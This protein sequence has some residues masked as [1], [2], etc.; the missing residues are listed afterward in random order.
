MSPPPG[1]NDTGSHGSGTRLI[2]RLS[3]WLGNLRLDQRFALTGSGVTL[4][5]MLVVGTW[6]N[7]SITENVVRNS[8]QS[9]AVYIEGLIAPLSQDLEGGDALSDAAAAR[10]MQLLAEPSASSRIISAKIWK[11]GGL[12]VFSTDAS[13]IGKRFA[14]GPRLRGAW[15]GRLMA[16]FDELDGNESNGERASGLPLLETYNPIHSSVTGE[17]I[18]VAELYQNGVS[19]RRDLFHARLKSWLLVAT[20]MLSTFGVLFGIVRRGSQ[21]IARQYAELSTQ[22]AEVARVSRQNEILSRR[23]QAASRRSGE[24]N[25]RYLRRISAELHDGPAQALALAT[26]RLGAPGEGRIGAQAAEADQIRLS[27]QEAL[28]DIRLL[29]R[30]LT[31]P[32]LKNVSIGDVVTSAV[33]AHRRRTGIAAQVVL[34][35]DFDAGEVPPHSTSICLYRFVQEGLMNAFRHAEAR[36]LRVTCRVS[37][38]MLACTVEDDGRGFDPSVPPSRA[39]SIGLEGLR[40]RVESIGGS[41]QVDSRPGNGTRLTLTLSME[42]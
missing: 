36:A 24:L 34:G 22:L 3:G 40:E 41:L 26:M 33:A 5:G 23:V 35:S 37:D 14:E 6:V 10:L 1:S 17:I 12:I 38:H 19:L 11:K 30:G 25:E 27:L 13:L 29:C 39:Q 15:N 4:V 42:S 21:T 28:R 31:L 16:A 8:V 9:T 7:A 32:E 2:D 20:I 18:A